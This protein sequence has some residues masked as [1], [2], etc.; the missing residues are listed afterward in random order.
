MAS[1][2]QQMYKKPQDA[3]LQAC[4]KSGNESRT[5]M[6]KHNASPPIA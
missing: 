3:R 2:V 6:Q 4:E 5:S 1:D